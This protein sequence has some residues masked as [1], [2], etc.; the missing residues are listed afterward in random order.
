MEDFAEMAGIE[1]VRIGKN[2]ELYQFKNEL[3]CSEVYYQANNK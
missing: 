1:Y 3:R 2:T